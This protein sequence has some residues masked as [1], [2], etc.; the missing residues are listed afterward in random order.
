MAQLT[1]NSYFK[2][3]LANEVFAGEPHKVEADYNTLKV[4]IETDEVGVLSV[5]QS[6][7]S[8]TY[9]SYGDVFNI[10]GRTHKQIH[11]KGR[12][13]YV[14]YE[15]GGSD[16]GNFTLYSVLSKSVADG[17]GLQEVLVTNE[18]LDVSGAVS[19]NGLL[20][21]ASGNLKVS[22]VS[23]GGVSSNV[24]VDNFPAEQA[25]TGTFWQATQP[26]SI[27][28]L[29]TIEIN[30]FPVEQAVT[31][32]FWQA[33]QPVSIADELAVRDASAIELL[34]AIADG[35]V[36]QVGEVD[37][38]GV[39]LVDGKLPTLD[40]SAI[41]VLETIYTATANTDINTTPIAYSPVHLDLETQGAA[42]WA[43]ST[44]AW[45]APLNH[46]QGWQY[47]NTT[48]GGANLY[49][50]GNTALV[51]GGLEP[52]IT[53]GSLMNMS[54]VGNY[55]LLLD[56]NPNKK[57]YI[58][59]TT[60]PT[61]TGDYY[62]GVFHS[63]KVWE[64][65]AST[66]VSKGADYLFYAMDDITSFR[67]DLEH[68]QMVLAISNGDCGAAEIVQFMSINVDSGTTVN[69]FSGIVKEAYFSTE[70]GANRQVVFDNSIA[71]KADLAL[72]K[73]SVEMGT[74]QVNMSGFTFNG[75]DELLVT[76]QTYIDIRSS[77]I[78][79][80]HTTNGAKE[81]LDVSVENIV[82]C[83]T[84][85]VVIS[86]GSV[87]VSGDVGLVAGTQVNLLDSTVGLVENTTVGIVGDVS[88]ISGATALNVTESNPITGFNLE[89]TQ[90]DIKA[91]TDKL[92]FDTA[93]GIVF[94]LRTSITNTEVPVRIENVPVVELQAG[95]SIFAKLQDGNENIISSTAS[96]A[97][98]NVLNTRIFGYDVAN[99]L[100]R[101]VRQGENGGLFV[102]NITSVDFE[103]VAKNDVKVV[104]A[105]GTSLD[106]HCFGSSD[107]TTFHHLKTT[108]TGELVTHSQT[109]DGAGTA[110]TSTA[111]GGI[112][113]LDVAISGTPTISGEVSTKAQATYAPQ[114]LTNTGVT[115]PAQIGT[116]A[117]SQGF[118]WVS[119]LLTF[120]SVTTGGQI[121]IEVS[122]DSSN[123]ARPSAG[124]V[125]VMSSGSN[126]T[127]SILL[128]VPVAMRYVRLYA[129]SPFVGVGCNA[130]FSMK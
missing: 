114:V 123:W 14:K 116:V 46:E 93:D 112:T 23:G 36:V 89:T 76:K 13:V 2:N 117:D 111:N 65:P 58:S 19:V 35:I 74:L 11:I 21:D 102:E 101:P 25:V 66:V 86:S 80:T 127:A 5:F 87:S 8:K 39:S 50:Y 7:D 81:C 63:R 59:L 26:V 71:R 118:L 96:E 31:G 95:S 60:K 42:A 119:A 41:A 113:A 73:L 10:T 57:F 124:S 110:I 106:V 97:N 122:P 105:T 85:A 33:T 18:Y 49:F 103:V 30:N 68:K 82:A 77:G 62:P 64:L 55:R 20:F 54:F 108:A 22:G 56:S 100:V 107:G 88:V 40:A 109:R 125:F 4:T 27:D 83:D 1:R 78:D 16:T 75:D 129:D 84:G 3:L 120:T 43:D 48:A 128:G 12:Y 69:Q 34:A 44:L 52:D 51:V 91:K 37:I 98:G 115:G 79:L 130:F 28:T 9:N 90:A 67:R 121:Y 47:N 61:G 104:N 70:G 17:V 15:N 32:T 38:S 29:P 94:D 24:T 72:S 92:N 126:V 53:L 45:F 6:I 99:D